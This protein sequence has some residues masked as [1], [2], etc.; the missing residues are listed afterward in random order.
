[1]VEEVTHAKAN[2]DRM[3]IPESSIG[4]TRRQFIRS[5]LGW[6]ALSKGVVANAA[7]ISLHCTP[8]PSFPVPLTEGVWRSQDFPVGKHNYHVS[9]D[10]DRRMPLEE[11]DCDLGPPRPG[12][13]CASPPLLD[14]E[15]KIWDGAILVENWSAKPVRADAWSESS[16]SCILGG[17]DGKKNG[18][19]IL[20]LNVKRDAGRLKDLHPRVHIVKNPGYWCWL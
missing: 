9:L 10:V 15:W 2:A 8:A 14:L 6:G 1:M 13:Q 18:R 19:F 20:E 3:A 12:Y 16:T 5:A 11:L 7:A 17:F 4:M